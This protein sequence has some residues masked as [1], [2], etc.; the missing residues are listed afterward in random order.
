MPLAQGILDAERFMPHGMCYLWEPDLL[1]LHVASDGVTG[2][3]YFAISVALVLL[4]YRSARLGADEAPGLRT[5]PFWWMFVAFGV[6]IVACG[7]TH[8]LAV[9]TV[10]QPDYW[11]AGG[12][13]GVT[14]VFSL[15]TA[16]ALPPLI[17]RVL[18]T[19][20][21]AR[22]SEARKRGLERANGE[23][24]AAHQRIKE[25]DE[26]K[27]RFFANVSHELRTP[28]TLIS[29]PTE[30]LLAREEIP[31]KERKE[32]E[33]VAR[34]ARLL[35][36]HVSDILATT[37]LAAGRLAPTYRKADVA[38][39]GRAVASAFRGIAR[40]REMEFDVQSPETLPAE[41]D[42][43]MLERVLL[44]LLSNAFK[45]TPAG[46]TVRLEIGTA[47]RQ[48]RSPAGEGAEV[49]LEVR[50]SGKGI[51]PEQR[52]V[53]FER[54]RQ[55]EGGTVRPFGGTG[56]GLAIVR[57]LV[58]L[59][60]GTVS[61]DDAPEGGARLRVRLPRWA[62]EG[63]EVVK[64]AEEWAS[65]AGRADAEELG[66]AAPPRP[67]ERPPEDE[68]A[69]GEDAADAAADAA[70]RPPRPSVLVVEDSPDMAVFVSS[71]LDAAFRVTVARDGR[72]A[73]ERIEE[74]VPDLILSDIMM[75]GMGGDELLRRVRSLHEL[76]P[77]P[78]LFLTARADD[79][80]KLQMFHEGAQD[81]ITKPF[82]PEEILSRVENWTAV[83]RARKLL[84]RELGVPGHD[85][86]ELARELAIRKATLERAL[87]A[88]RIA[89]EE[90]AQTNRRRTE[91]LGT[92]SHE[93]RT[94]LNAI[95]GY[96]DLLRAGVDGEISEAQD[97]RLARIEASGLRLR[98]L[99]DH[100]LELSSVDPKRP[101]LQW[102]EVS[103]PELVSDVTTVVEAEA[104]S[105]GLGFRRVDEAGETGTLV[106]DPGRLRQILFNLLSNAVEYTDE[107]EV[108]LR[109][110]GD[111][112]RVVFEVEDTG[113]GISPRDRARIFDPFWRGPEGAEEAR[114]G[115]GLSIARRLAERLGGTLEVE[116]DPDEGS[117][118]T[119]K[120]PRRPQ[121][122]PDQG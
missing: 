39:L 70:A 15:A 98:E 119:V 111:A 108:R 34:N 64:S 110:S 27:T 60:G 21:E 56:L 107:G 54:F 104:R 48:E 73:L 49:V 89:R 65:E 72:E 66:M 18:E 106:T 84:S 118:F 85:V 13:K 96:A 25:L 116:S 38:R 53:I 52:E 6:F 20:Q 58:E 78:F 101:R 51:P 79:D 67:S 22:K 29:G 43:D 55:V 113:P 30:R 103:V 120:L 5:I 81:Y 91:M 115:L 40:E 3:S 37:R 42:P 36:R 71:V 95:L 31:E 8:L 26:L 4:V 83:A 68:D 76:D 109:V 88:E 100:L 117:R 61:V 93:L 32:L 90:E 7:A 122:A 17:P 33:I 87:E 41:L 14:A 74:S 46:G 45:F 16:V 77:V 11:I 112:E 10:W 97:A 1:T 94:P 102:Q 12:V 9:W 99:I 44:N 114:V 47:S 121:E 69:L 19:V 2:L 86:E 24:R 23:L 63:A 50:D 75:P 92:V 28:L 82:I 105:A 62:P 59:H 57:D 80:L 35:E